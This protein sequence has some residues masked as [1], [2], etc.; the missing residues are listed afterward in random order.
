MN[1][2]PR[3]YVGLGRGSSSLWGGWLGVLLILAGSL[4]CTGTG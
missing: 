2:V 4:R 1:R 3:G